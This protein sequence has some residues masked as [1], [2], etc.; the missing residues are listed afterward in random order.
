MYAIRSYYVANLL[1]K[2]EKPVLVAV[3]KVDNAM[4]VADAVE[5][6][7]LGLGEYFTI[8]GMS[9]SGTGELLDIV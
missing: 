7:S 6:Y 3:N 8:A 1:R 9:G 2:V 4:R 5:F